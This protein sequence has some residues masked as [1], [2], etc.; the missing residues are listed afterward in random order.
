[1]E[2]YYD[3]LNAIAEEFTKEYEVKPTRVQL[4]SNLAYDKLARN[5][6]ELKNN[7]MIV[8]DPLQITEKGRDFLH[9]YNRIAN[10]VFE[11]G[12]RYLD[13]SNVEGKFKEY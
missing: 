5:L 12:I 7:K 9:D 13:S 1:M 10:F 11:M 6:D 3:I 4:L 2:L 8:Q